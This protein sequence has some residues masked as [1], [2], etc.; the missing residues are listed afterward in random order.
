[1]ALFGSGRSSSSTEEVPK[2]L[3]E[4][5]KRFL[6]GPQDSSKRP[7]KGHQK[8]QT[9]PAILPYNDGTR[10]TLEA[11][12]ESSVECPN[13][14]CLQELFKSFYALQQECWRSSCDPTASR[15]LERL[16]GP[17]VELLNYIVASVLQEMKS[18][19]ADPQV[20]AVGVRCHCHCHC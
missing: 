4:V 10:Y 5:P 8:S 12:W 3:K 19:P 11:G 6:R 1:M 17:M 14:D 16:R 7:K 15:T 18:Q 13:D 9:I 2:R 20:Q